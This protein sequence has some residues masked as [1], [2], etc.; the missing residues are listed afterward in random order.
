[1][2]AFGEP[3]HVVASSFDTD[4]ITLNLA[5]ERHGFALLTTTRGPLSLDGAFWPREVVFTADPRLAALEGRGDSSQPQPFP[6]ERRGDDYL[7]PWQGMRDFAF[8]C[9]LEESGGRCP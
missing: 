8:Y 3:S 5:Y 9:K 6:A 4:W 2:A 7:Q 1:I